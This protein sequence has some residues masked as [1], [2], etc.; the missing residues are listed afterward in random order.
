MRVQDL[1]FFGHQIT[2]PI[3]SNITARIGES[4]YKGARCLSAYSDKLEMGFIKQ[5]ATNN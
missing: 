2:R 3:S 5:Y 1:S 4:V